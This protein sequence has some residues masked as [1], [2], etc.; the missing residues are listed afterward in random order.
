[1]SLTGWQV[2]P[3]DGQHWLLDNA[4]GTVAP[5]AVVILVRQGRTGP[6]LNTG[7]TIQ[8]I[9]P[10]GEIVDTR[11]YGLATSGQLIRFD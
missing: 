6:L 9:N 2:G 3:A 1:M 8:L 10:A 7:G 4:D 5:G 11:S